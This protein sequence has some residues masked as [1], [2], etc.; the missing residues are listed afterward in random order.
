MKKILTL[1]T[2]VLWLS[3]M[4]LKAQSVS[5]A[6]LLIEQERY[7]DA[8]KQL[9]PLADAGDAEAQYLSATLFFEG[10]GVQKNVQQGVKYATLSANQ[11]NENSIALLADYYYGTGNH[12][13]MFGMLK[14]LINQHPYMEEKLSGTILGL[15][16]LNGY[17]TEKDAKRGRELL[18]KNKKGQS[19]LNDLAPRLA[20]AIPALMTNV[21]IKA[22]YGYDG[23]TRRSVVYADDSKICFGYDFEANKTAKYYFSF[24]IQR[25]D[26]TLAARHNASIECGPG[27]Q[28]YSSWFNIDPLPE[29]KYVVAIVAGDN[30]VLDQKSFQVQSA[31]IHAEKMET[32]RHA[33]AVS[34]IGI[35]TTMRVR[36][37]EVNN[38]RRSGNDV[39]L[40]FTV[41][42]YIGNT[43]YYVDN[44]RYTEGSSTTS[45]GVTVFS[46]SGTEVPGG[47][48][49]SGRFRDFTMRYETNEK[50]RV[51]RKDGYTVSITLK[52]KAASTCFIRNVYVNVWNSTQKNVGVVTLSNVSW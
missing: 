22:A 16:Y 32:V 38:C 10:K 11:G 39:V 28:S 42:P 4:Q 2:A 17:G 49:N 23:D 41:Y 27:K 44:V 43:E 24:F 36:G 50:R 19:M 51:S 5:Y 18:G 13:K 29:G 3:V 9:R 52:N 6:K 7:M 25:L 40:T 48:P 1:L 45:R 37:V 30:T 21:E 31:D 26:G 15:C 8:A 47:N 12:Q 35:S 46:D 33:E 14:E 34:K 20:E